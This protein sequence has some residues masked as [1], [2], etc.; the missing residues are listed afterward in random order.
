MKWALRFIGIKG[1]SKFIKEFPSWEKTFSEEELKNIY[2]HFVEYSGSVLP[3]L[4]HELSNHNS[5]IDNPHRA[6]RDKL[7]AALLNYKS[8]FG[9][10]HWEE[11]AHHFQLS[12]A[13][14]ESIVS[15]FVEDIQHQT[16]SRAD[17]YIPLFEKLKEVEREAFKPLL[18][19]REIDRSK[20]AE[21][22]L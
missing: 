22:I 9:T 3:E 17:R 18:H 5:G 7:A 11:A 19:T 2:L 14:I 4:P 21:L 15:G 20:K 1:I 10:P 12:G 13:I 6:S 16:F 8:T